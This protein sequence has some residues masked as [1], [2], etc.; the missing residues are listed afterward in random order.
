[1]MQFYIGDLLL[2]GITK[3]NFEKLTENKPIYFEVKSKE[4]IKNI[5]IMYGDD[6]VKM[7]ENLQEMGMDIPHWMWESVRENP[8]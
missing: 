3:R 4:P 7:L 5:C 8:T 2:L 1:M 6:K